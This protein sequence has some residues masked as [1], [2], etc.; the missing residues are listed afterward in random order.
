MHAYIR[1]TQGC[2]LRDW[3]RLHVRAPSPPTEEKEHFCEGR[4][5]LAYLFR[6]VVFKC[7]AYGAES[8]SLVS[9]PWVWEVGGQELWQC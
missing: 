3:E 2:P 8:Y 4:L 7:M 5:F 1:G 9:C 6:P